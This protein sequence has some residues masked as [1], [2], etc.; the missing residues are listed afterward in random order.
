MPSSFQI[1]AR[2]GHGFHGGGLGREF[3]L[4]FVLID[5]MDKGL[6]K[7]IVDLAEAVIGETQ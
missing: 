4:L 2:L 6:D 1:G 7:V 3:G 5:E